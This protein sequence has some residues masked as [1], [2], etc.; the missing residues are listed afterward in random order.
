MSN[1]IMGII[2]DF[3]Y[4]VQAFLCIEFSH[5][6]YHSE[7]VVY[8]PAAS[9]LSTVGTGIFPCC[10]QKVLRFDPTQLTKVNIE[11]CPFVVIVLTNTFYL[12]L[13][14]FIVFKV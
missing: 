14:L 9:S 6:Q 10:N 11:C 5:C 8:P 2:I 4:S 7:A 12:N 1:C 3:I 13:F